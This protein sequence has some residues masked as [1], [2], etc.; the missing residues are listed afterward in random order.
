VAATALMGMLAV[1]P[2][3]AS[4]RSVWHGVEALAALERASAVEAS[5]HRLAVAGIQI[6]DPN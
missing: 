3:W 1:L 4:V 2:L 6:G 5:F